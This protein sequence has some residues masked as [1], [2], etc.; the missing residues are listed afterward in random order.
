[1]SSLSR[2]CSAFAPLVGTIALAWSVTGG[3]LTFGGGEKDIVLILPVAI[4]SVLFAAISLAMW[5]RSA[6]IARASK[7]AAVAALAVLLLLFAA[8]VVLTWQ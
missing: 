7:L 3:P 6:P 4:W 5:A 1:M 8:F 2:L